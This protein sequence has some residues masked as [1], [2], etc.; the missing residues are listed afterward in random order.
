MAWLALAASA[1]AG[2]LLWSGMS[3]ARQRAVARALAMGSPALSTAG[4]GQRMRLLLSQWRVASADR[5]QGLLPE[6]LKLLARDL[7]QASG[8]GLAAGELALLGMVAGPGLGLLFLL[9]GASFP[10][11]LLTVLGGMALPWIRE[12]DLARQRLD[13]IQSQLPDAMDLLASAMAAGLGFEQALSR[14]VPL[15]EKGPLQAAMEKAGQRMSL[16]Q[17]REE[18]L[19][20]LDRQC[21][22][23][24]VSELVVALVQGTRQGLALAPVLRSQARQARRL[25]GLRA[26][27]AAAQ[28][29]IKLLFPLMV[30][31]LPVVFLVL[32]GPIYLAWTQGGF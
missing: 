20:E 29:P 25:A 23:H 1:A 3:L 31:I 12:K 19:R 16:G 8:S 30:F 11:A 24:D 9:A 7:V 18:S 5:A 27:K 10:L 26:Q 17:S 21:R 22:S 14:V 32:L 6:R 28:A 15:L 13:H 2:F 4:R